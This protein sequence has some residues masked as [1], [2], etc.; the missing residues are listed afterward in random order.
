[1][2]FEHA[3]LMYDDVSWYKT[4]HIVAIAINDFV[5]GFVVK[6]GFRVN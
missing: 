1:V 4:Y 2:G 3:L 6:V 5:Y